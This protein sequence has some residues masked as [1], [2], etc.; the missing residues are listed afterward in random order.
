MAP[1]MPALSMLSREQC[2]GRTSRGHQ[3]ALYLGE[4]D[5]GQD[6][7]GRTRFAWLTKYRP[8]KRPSTKAGRWAGWVGGIQALCSVGSGIKR[9]AQLRELS[10]A[11]SGLLSLSILHK[12]VACH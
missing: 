5:C 2:G 12:V 9:G 11:V 7:L 1:S 6:T 4:A 10:L 8:S 3:V